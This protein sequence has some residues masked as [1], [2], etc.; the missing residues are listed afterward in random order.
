[1]IFSLFSHFFRFGRIC[2]ESCTLSGV[3]FKKGVVVVVPVY[4][5]HRDPEYWP[6]PEKFDPERYEEQI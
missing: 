4:H 3:H 6:D 1:M 5:L 2:N